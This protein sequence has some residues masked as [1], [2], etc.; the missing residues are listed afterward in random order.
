MKGMTFERLLPE[1]VTQADFDRMVDLEKNCGLPDPYPPSLIASLLEEVDTFVCRHEGDLIGFIMVTEHGKYFGGSVYIVNIN[2]SA[3]FRGQGAAKRLILEAVRYFLRRRPDRLM[4]LDV[5]LSN[6]ALRLYEKIGFR[7]TMLHSRNG[8][9]DIVMA[10]PLKEI[11]Q[12]L[13]IL[14]SASEDA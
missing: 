2:V 12:R 1:Q 13:E 3:A 4:S 14:L 9:S 6:P 10:A 11:R 5:T 8:K 7:R